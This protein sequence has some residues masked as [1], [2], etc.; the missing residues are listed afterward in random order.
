MEGGTDTW[1]F[2]IRGSLGVMGGFFVCFCFC[3]LLFVNV[4][5]KV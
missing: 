1:R 5:L 4:C 2:W 3:D